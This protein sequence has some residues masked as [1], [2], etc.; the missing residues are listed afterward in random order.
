MRS[1][2]LALLTSTSAFAADKLYF[3]GPE[4]VKLDWNTSCPRAADFNGDG[5]TDIAIINQ[6]R[7]RLEFLIQRKDGIRPGEPERSSR[8]DRWNPILEISRF[9]KQPFVIGHSAFA[10]TVGDWNGDKRPD[11]AYV[12]DEEKLILRTQ[13]A[14]P[15]DWTQK[16]EFILDSTA[17]D[18]ESLL[19][20][21]LNGDGKSD[22]AL[23][24]D[25]RLMVWLQSK[26]GWAEVKSYVLGQSGCGGLRTGDLNGDGKADLFYTSPD[27]DA[28]L[29]RLQQEGASFGEEWRLETEASRCWTHPVKLGKDSK[30]TGLGYIH[31][32][33]GMVEIAKL[34]TGAVEPNADRAASIRYAMPASDAKGGAVAFGDLNGDDIEDV[35][36]TEAKNARLW[37]FA[38]VK[39]GSFR[40]GREFPALSGI[41]TLAIADVDGDEKAEL[42]VSSPG[43]KSI[44]LAR[45]QKD[46]LAYPEVIHQSTDTLLTLTAGN[47]TGEKTANVLVLTDVKGK[48][49]L[50]SLK[51]N[52]AEKKFISSTQE[53]T[54]A[55]G[56]PNAVRVIDAN[57]DGRGDLALFSTLA[58]M[59]VLLSQTDAKAPFKR[60]EGLPDSLVNKISP[61]ALTSADVNGDGKDE[62]IVAK[63]QLARAFKVGADGKAVTVEQ[64]NA[65]DSTSQLSA[66]LVAKV[67]GNMTVLLADS[68][69]QKLHEMVPGTDG[70]FRAG[71]THAL[72]SLSAEQMHMMGDKLLVISKTSFEIT[73]LSGSAMK[74]DTLVSFDSE[75]KDT[76][77]SD[78][79]PAAFSGLDVDDIA[80]VDF[81]AS[82][83]LELFQPDGKTPPAWSSAMY[84]RIF[85]TD[86]HFRGKSGRE[87]EPHDY[88]SLDL[89]ADGKLDLVLLVHDRMLIYVRK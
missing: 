34:A 81:S 69:Q 48:A 21:D 86:P 6:D 82:R 30:A 19:S 44:G 40:E 5:L 38:G 37:F 39:G 72:S 46:R 12:T 83:V 65:P 51:W 43:E 3:E 41:E 54:S 88:T 24:T 10:L 26:D 11:I 42:I 28:V 13:G 89:N 27:A 63:D 71:R 22:L 2:A 52:A 79:I 76:K 20:L 29:V 31:D 8:S 17:D 57:Q 47:V 16:K 9:D 7:A 84:F 55:T 53:L 61:V 35:V 4:V 45:W 64:F 23:L 77:P 36:L 73:P 78:L 60:A 87:N 33:T 15:G 32:S 74:L 50:L 66:V 18:S 1:L 56:K 75:L 58:P 49:N 14:K 68:A 85:E 25:T 70:V 67:E 59:Q 80:L 62:I